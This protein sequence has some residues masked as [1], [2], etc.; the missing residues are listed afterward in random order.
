MLVRRLTA[1]LIAVASVAGP[2][3]VASADPGPD[4]ADLVVVRVD[5][6]G[7]SVEVVPVDTAAQAAAQTAAL[8]QDPAVLAVEPRIDW[9]PLS[10]PSRPDQTYLDT[11][12]LPVAWQT[13]AGAGQVVAV[14]DTG[15]EDIPDLAGQ[16]A[17][18]ENFAPGT[19]RGTHGTSVASIIAAVRDNGTGISGVAPSA[20]LLDGRVCD[21]TCP[22]DAVA[23]GLLWAADNDAD[24]INVSL[25]GTAYSAVVHEAIRYAVARGS[26][27]VAAAGNFGTAGNP[28]TSPR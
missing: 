22:S 6:D 19:D 25:G 26:V 12:N 27:V 24:V 20:R 2:A 17:G 1:V 18:R 16:V 13:T 21:T 14:L 7:L 11:A 3:G 8:R 23:R 28:R 10:D 4:V 9:A 5:G 15:I